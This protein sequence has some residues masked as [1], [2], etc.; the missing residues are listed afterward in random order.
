M[1]PRSAS[2]NGGAGSGMAS[3]PGGATDAVTPDSTSANGHPSAAAS[4]PSVDG[5]SPTTTPMSPK[6]SR[7]MPTVGASGFPD[8]SGW[9][10]AA[11]ATAATSDPAP[12]MSPPGTG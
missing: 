11:V 5:R 9:A 3:P 8:T 4:P 6:R 1:A 10:P 7:M 12:G 2:T